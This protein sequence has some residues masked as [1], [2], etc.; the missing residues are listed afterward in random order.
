MR[1][2][3]AILL[4]NLI[5][6]SRNRMRLIFTVFMSVTFLFIFS[7]IMKSAGANIVEPMN[8]LI[9]GIII[10][11]VFQTALNNSMSIL[12]DISDGFMKEILVAPIARWQ[13]AVGQILS[14]AT[15]AAL[16][17]VIIM[18]IGCFMGF[19]TDA[20]HF[21]GMMGLMFLIGITFSSIGLFLAA[22]A[23]ESTTFQ[24]MITVVS[25]PLTFLSGAYIP[26]MVLPK[27]LYPVVFLNP[28]TYTTAI[29]R[30]WALEMSDLTSAQLVQT[31]VAF[32]INGIIIM[33][34]AGALIV[35]AI[36]ALFFGLCVRQFSHADFS[37]VKAFHRHH[38]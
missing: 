12:E 4:R 1:T 7:F 26:T 13:I 30:Y 11:T 35:F 2:I 33:P 34:Y 25:M 23:K 20:T 18:I 9:S 6:F 21:L 38:S 32:D 24:I 16:Q 22:L 8:Y 37:R 36:G 29:F 19:R 3:K 14:S 15:I 31:G 28:L 17:G 27:I 5:K 10:M